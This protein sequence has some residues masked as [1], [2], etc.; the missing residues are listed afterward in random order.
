M[1]VNRVGTTASKGSLTI[2][3][4]AIICIIYEWLEGKGHASCRH[5]KMALYCYS[6]IGEFFKIEVKISQLASLQ[7]DCVLLKEAATT[8]Q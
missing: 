4:L 5:V 2:N 7:G 1:V 8:A 3:Y 6:N